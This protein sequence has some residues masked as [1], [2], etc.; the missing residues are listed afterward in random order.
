VAQV[1]DGSWSF[2]MVGGVPVVTAPAE[3]DI[4]TAGQLRAMLAGWAARG[5]TT[6]VVDL[7][8]TQFCDCTGLHVLVRAHKQA[9]AEGGG[10]RLLLPASGPVPRIFTLTGLDRVIPHFTSLEQALAQ[11]PDRRVRPPRPRSSPGMRSRAEHNAIGPIGAHLDHRR[12]WSAAPVVQGPA[13]LGR[14]EDQPAE[15]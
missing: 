1:P 7:A 15:A 11:V 9:Q 2:L 10:L 3:I 12:P 14:G 8:G 4:T 5:H 13:R 6:V